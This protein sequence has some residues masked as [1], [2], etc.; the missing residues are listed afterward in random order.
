MSY[1]SKVS[2]SRIDAYGNLGSTILAA[3]PSIH[4]TAHEEGIQKFSVFE[5]P[6]ELLCPLPRLRQ[7]RQE[8]HQ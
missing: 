5:V 2:G 7:A 1:A 4:L 6:V 3:A 8:E